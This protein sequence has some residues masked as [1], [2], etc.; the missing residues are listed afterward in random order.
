MARPEKEI[1]SGASLSLRSLAI[2]LR[3]PLTP[4]CALP[5]HRI[6]GS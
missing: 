1:D 3:L 2:E 6:G 5:G 4:D